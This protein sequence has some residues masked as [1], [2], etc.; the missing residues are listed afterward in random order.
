MGNQNDHKGKVI[1]ISGPSGVG[2]STICHEVIRRINAFLSI[3]ITTRP[4]GK[5]EVDGEDYHFVSEEEFQK[6]IE[7]GDFLEY[8]RVFGHYYGTPAADVEQALDQ[9]KVVILEI[10]VQGA[11]EVKK[12]YSDAVMIFIFPPS[13][14][15]LA[16]RMTDRARGEEGEVARQR[17]DSASQEI[18][19][20]WQYY[21]HM[22]INADLQQAVEEI[23]QIIE[24]ENQEDIR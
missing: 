22:V 1:I 19:A 2:K 16:G 4:R 9:G 3:S 8:A 17:L 24:E 6:R 23:I 5:T 10:D 13:Q 7:N 12:V 15:D 18:A 20:A 14:S 21:H 11:R